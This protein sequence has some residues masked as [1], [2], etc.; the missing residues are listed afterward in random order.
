MTD[1][2][3]FEASGDDISGPLALPEDQQVVT[4]YQFVTSALESTG[5]S[6]LRGVE[7]AGAA[8]VARELYDRTQRPLLFIARDTE[9]AGRLARDLEYMLRE[10]P[11]R[12]TTPPV[13]LYFAAEGDPY[14]RVHVDRNATMQ[15]LNTLHHIAAGL[16]WSVLV[17]T[18]TALARRVL[19]AATL[20][21]ASPALAKGQEVDATELQRQL[22]EAGYLRVP[23]VEDPGCFA[24]RGGLMDI[25]SPA[26]DQPVRVE[27][28]GDVVETLRLFSPEDQRSEAH[29]PRVRL[30]PVREAQLSVSLCEQARIALRSLCDDDNYPSKKARSLVVTVT[31][32]RS[33][34]SVDAYTPAFAELVPLW[35]A[36]PGDSPVLIEEPAGFSDSL[37]DV[38][39]AARMGFEHKAEPH[40]APTAL[41]SSESAVEA[42]LEQRT[43]LA[44]N[45]NLIGGNAED[46]FFSRLEKPELDTPTLATRDHSDLDRAIRTARTSQGRQGA[47]DPLLRRLGIWTENGLSV[48]IVARTAGQ[49]RR[50]L[51]LLSH[52]GVELR[53]VDIELGDRDVGDSDPGHSDLGDDNAAD[54]DAVGSPQSSQDALIQLRI[55]NLARGAIAPAE[56]KVW[57]TEQEIFGQ[58]ARQAPTRKRS[59]RAQL[60]DLRALETG[61]F[62]VH[63]EH[64]IG[65]YHGLQHKTVGGVTVDL[66][67]V[68]YSGGDKLYLPAYRLN[69]LTKYS[70]GE[71]NPRIDKLGGLSFSRTKSKVKKKVREM[72]DELLRLYAERNNVQK[73]PLPPP[74]DDYA[75]FEASFPFE[76]T[77]DQAAAIAD[78]LSDTQNKRVMD[79]LICGDV[80]FGKTE[81]A[82]RA[83]FRY[84][85]NGR[86]VALLCPTTVLAQQHFLT[87]QKRFVDYAIEVQAMS[88]FQSTEAVKE[89]KKQI[90]KGTVDI[91][92]GTHR[93]LSRDVHFKNLGLVIV[94]EEQRFGVAHKE[95]LKQL[96]AEVDVM[97]LSATPIPR[98]LQ[99]AVGG[100]REMSLISTPPVDRRAIR[101]IT[102]SFDEKLIQEALLR[103]LSRGGQIFYVFNR[104]EGIYERAELVRRL[105]PEARIAVG[106][107][108][109]KEAELERTMLD[110]VEGRI[111]VLVATSIIESGL[112]IP[113]ANTMIIDRA[114]LFGLSQLYQLRGRVGRS[115]ERAYCYMLVP[116]QDRLT[117]DARHRIEA[118]ERHTQ[119]GSGFQIATLDMEL[120]G[121]GNLLG[122]DQSGLSTAVGF[123]LFCQMLEEATRELSGDTLT[124]EVDPELNFDVDAFLPEAYIREVGVRLSVYKRFASALLDTEVMSLAA[125][126]EDRF[127]RP[128]IEAERLVELMRLK[129]QLRELRALGCEGTGR[130]VTLHL[131]EDTPL[132]P[133]KVGTLVGSKNSAY[134]LS[135]DMRLTRKL[136]AGE[137]FPDGL[138]LADKM[139]TELQD[140]TTS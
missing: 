124:A 39:E 18:H 132:D 115:R 70:G 90:R 65:R 52:R 123:D 43:V 83:A 108:Q 34:F 71:G 36:L 140:L 30:P 45:R 35:E 42:M 62:V 10:G 98:T 22:S 134:K 48:E 88:R 55:G 5:L 56:G 14:A 73:V 96:R 128:P 37:C 1:H 119:L 8:L 82:L 61:D 95:R 66:L 117:D 103:E 24:V 74:G 72:A 13:L 20:L 135:P 92:I 139:L 60:E 12:S 129:T 59:A 41:F 94:D 63:V 81:V 50:A 122:G 47:L 64:G 44:L 137:S 17:T 102:A 114:D 27:F 46:G 118:L 116:S 84:A 69:Q 32:G 53:A 68:E 51:S 101:T 29:I 104:V 6:A 125:E 106:H 86:Q 80:G 33:F 21:Q 133:E 76:E 105:V 23:V 11:N 93:L 3:A 2:A 26:L 77:S 109:M 136:R 107:G 7:G 9:S 78:M 75:E 40:F 110:F 138:A 79:R 91:V 120:R 31:E 130:I 89:T 112:D 16:P 49:A 127:G 121:A 25:W 58:R 4:A 87:F 100:L 131:R 97:T 111:D 38:W 85:M 28:D 113:R 54:S 126:M 15:R 99:L 67:L 19:P 57:I